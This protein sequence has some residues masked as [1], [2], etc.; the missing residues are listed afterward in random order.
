MTTFKAANPFLRQSKADKGW[1]VSFE[2]SQD[3]WEAIRDL[4]TQAY[5]GIILNISVTEDG[6]S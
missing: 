3:Q 5:E 6:G 4:P 1:T 2:V